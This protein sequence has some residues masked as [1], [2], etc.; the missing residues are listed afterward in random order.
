M[1]CNI[2]AIVSRS[3]DNQ[4]STLTSNAVTQAKLPR[5]CRQF[6]LFF[7]PAKRYAVGI[8]HNSESCCLKGMRKKDLYEITT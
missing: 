5:F 2:G 1:L 7:N 3:L 8:K 6:C 4:F